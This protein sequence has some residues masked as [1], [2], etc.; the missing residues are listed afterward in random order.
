VTT[1]DNSPDPPTIS[2]A[3]EA[4]AA[5]TQRVRTALSRQSRG[6]PESTASPPATTTAASGCNTDSGASP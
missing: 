1:Y 6:I 4:S 3:D 2:P 5:A